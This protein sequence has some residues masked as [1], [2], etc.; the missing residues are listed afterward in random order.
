MQITINNVNNIDSAVIRLDAGVLNIKYAQNGTGKSTIARAIAAKIRNDDDALVA[1]RPFKYRGDLNDNTHA[2]IVGGVDSFHSIMVFNEDYVH[3]Y[4][5]TPDD[6]VKGTFEIFIKT[7]KYD[8]HMMNI[9]AHLKSITQVFRSDPE[10]D[11]LIG[12][13]KNLSDALGKPGTKGYS[14]SCSILKGLGNGNTIDNL[15]EELK[16]YASYL[17]SDEN[18][19]W[20]RWQSG[21]R[22][23][24]AKGDGACPYCASQMELCQY[25]RLETLAAT[26]DSKGLEHLVDSLDILERLAEYL[27]SDT[28]LEVQRIAKNVAKINEDDI[29]ILVNI[30]KQAD[31]LKERL[32]G[33]R[34]MNFERLKDVEKVSEALKDIKIQ[35]E[36]YPYFKSE[37]VLSKIDMINKSIDDALLSAGRLQGEVSKQKKLIT[38]TIE[39]Y[40]SAIERFLR[41]SGYPYRVSILPMGEDGYKTILTHEDLPDEPIEDA[42]SYLSYGE[43][44]ALALALFVFSAVQKNPDLIVLDDPIS[45]FDGKKKFSLLKMMFLS[46][47]K[48]CFRNRTVLMMTHDLCPVI[49]ALKVF[50]G[51]FSPIPKVDYLHTSNSKVIEIEVEHGDLLNI[52]ELTL[53]KVEKEETDVLFRAAY[54]RRLKEIDGEKGCSSYQMLS[55]LL[56]AKDATIK[57]LDG[58]ER[59]MTQDE[60]IEAEREIATYIKGFSFESAL[61]KA[62]DNAYLTSLYRGASCRKE[63]V[64]LFRILYGTDSLNPVVRKFVNETYHV[65]DEYLFQLD[66]E[67]YNGIPDFV[68]EELDKIVLKNGV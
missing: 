28:V 41:E 9:S 64:L 56:H 39:K 63:K 2:A 21:G 5:F 46:D 14:K 4:V 68:I 50:R 30:R 45:S 26:F 36:K 51:S 6:L 59:K 11:T 31:E 27:S 67:K 8:E 19:K 16:P 3:D 44:N 20:L 34:Y 40:N 55:S 43:R 29:S 22:A 66:P 15:P 7:P 62:K 12:V 57:M 17:T 49:D 25:K 48:E 32:E 38:T 65:E 18:V 23:F 37:R 54:L 10:I 13:C 24:T 61:K 1:L 47:A 35:A 42:P 53:K 58:Q 60:R 52:R 33:V